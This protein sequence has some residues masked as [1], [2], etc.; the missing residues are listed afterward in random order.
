MAY[1]MTAVPLDGV[2]SDARRRRRQLFRDK[3]VALEIAAASAGNLRLGRPRSPDP[4]ALNLLSNAVE[5]LRRRHRPGAGRD[6]GPRRQRDESPS[7]IMGRASRRPTA[8]TV[9]ERFRQG[10]DTLAGKPPGTRS[11]P[12]HLPH[13][14]APAQWRDLDRGRGRRRRDLQDPPV[15]PACRGGGRY[16]RR[17]SAAHT[18]RWRFITAPASLRASLV[19]SQTTWPLLRM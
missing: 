5:V 17:V 9:F 8:K 19:P 6:R 14:P 15:A 11:R 4:G 7:P 10:R 2:L 18:P 16:G 12:C 13:H 1:E 3:G